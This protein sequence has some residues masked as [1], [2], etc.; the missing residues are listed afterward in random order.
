MNF[1][2]AYDDFLARQASK[3]PGESRGIY[4]AG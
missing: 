1:G 2:G 4:N 3:P